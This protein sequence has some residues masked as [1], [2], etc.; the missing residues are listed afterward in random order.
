MVRSQ[1]LVLSVSGMIMIAA[2]S[3]F[4]SAQTGPI[5]QVAPKSMPAPLPGAAMTPQRLIDLLRSKGHQAELRTFPN[6]GVTVVSQISQN[7]WRYV[8]EFEYTLDQRTINLICPLVSAQQFS[9]AQL[10]DLL[11]KGFDLNPIHFSV[12][13]SD[14]RLCL[15]DPLYAAGNMTD[16]QLE[17]ILNNLLQ[18]V[19]DTHRLWDPSQATAAATPSFGAK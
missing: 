16:A 5:G 9:A 8:V 19:R 10:T 11:K 3:N 17:G 4:A 12:R 6:G 18:K 2:A 15:E 14:Q 13:S 7:G 1:I